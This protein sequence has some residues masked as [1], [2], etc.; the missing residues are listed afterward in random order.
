MYHFSIPFQEMIK[1]LEN[2]KLKYRQKGDTATNT[3][4]LKQVK[5]SSIS[6]SNTMK[7][8]AKLEKVLLSQI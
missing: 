5:F 6:S 3:P 2:Q 4:I 7:P 8:Q 1:V